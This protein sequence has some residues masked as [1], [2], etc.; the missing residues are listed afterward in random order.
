MSGFPRTATRDVPGMISLR[1]C[2]CLPLN[3]ER[4]RN[5]PVMLPP[6]RAMLST[7]PAS[8]GSISRIYP[9]DWDGTSCVFSGCQRPSASGEN[10]LNFEVCKFKCE[11]REK[12]GLV[13]RGSVFKCD[14]LPLDVP[15]LA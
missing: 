3:S 2:R 15:D 7:R 14:V 1:I 8:T 12:F 6:G 13:V 11:F 9:H 5:S 4:S 10:H